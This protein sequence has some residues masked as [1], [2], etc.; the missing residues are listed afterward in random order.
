MITRCALIREDGI[1]TNADGVKTTRR[2][3]IVQ[4]DSN[5]SVETQLAFVRPDL[6]EFQPHPDDSS[7]RIVSREF[8]Q[9]RHALIWWLDL[10]YSNQT[11]SEHPLQEPAEIDWSDIAVVQAITHD[12]NTGALLTATNGQLLELTEE[13]G[14]WQA[15][16][17]RNVAQVPNWFGRYARAINADFVRLDGYPCPPGTLKIVGASISPVV[18]TRTPHYRKLRLRIVLNEDGWQRTLLNRGLEEISLVRSNSGVIRKELMPILTDQ[19]TPLNEPAF[20]DEDGR[21]PRIDEDGR[22]V[23]LAQEM[24]AL[25]SGKPITTRVKWPL[26]P[27]D[28]VTVKRTTLKR[29]PFAALPL[30]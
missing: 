10:D 18:R 11:P 17:T 6:L 27:A 8:R 16:V 14:L 19:G 28:I 24:A 4:A 29:L 13:F 3:F 20:L 23:S 7:L 1:Q 5:V 2:R 30:R 21:R 26:D 15:N 25:R 22:R 12:P 9:Q